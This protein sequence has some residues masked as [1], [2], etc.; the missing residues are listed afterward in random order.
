MKRQVAVFVSAYLK[1]YMKRS[2]TGLQILE[3][4]AFTDFHDKMW[5]GLSG[6]WQKGG[7]P[8]FL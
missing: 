1:N 5:F 4:L 2:V 8:F 3:T 7:I 6:W